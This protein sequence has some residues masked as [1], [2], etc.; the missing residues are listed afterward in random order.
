MREEGIL[1]TIAA[2]P[3]ED[4]AEECEV[5]AELQVTIGVG[6]DVCGRPVGQPA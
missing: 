3:S 1:V 5:R 6:R 4:A 2:A